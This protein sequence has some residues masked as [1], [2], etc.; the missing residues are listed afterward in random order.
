MKLGSHLYGWLIVYSL[1]THTAWMRLIL[2]VILIMLNIASSIYLSCINVIIRIWSLRMRSY[3]LE[4][5][6]YLLILLRY[7]PVSLSHH[8]WLTDRL[9]LI[10]SC[11]HSHLGMILY[12]LLLSRKLILQGWNWNELR[13]IQIKVLILLL[14]LL[15]TIIYK[16]WLSINRTRRRRYARRSRCINLIIL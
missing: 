1:R 12:W 10:H 4:I 16:S 14:L 2:D 11:I 8:N 15:L 13:R 6:F 9:L 7:V 5:R 3:L